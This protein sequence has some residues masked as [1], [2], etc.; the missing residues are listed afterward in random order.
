MRHHTPTEFVQFKRLGKLNMSEIER[1]RINAY[2]HDG[3]R[4][5]DLVVGTIEGIRSGVELAGRG[6]KAILPKHVKH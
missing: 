3:E 4:I 2:I 6:I 5:A 1:E